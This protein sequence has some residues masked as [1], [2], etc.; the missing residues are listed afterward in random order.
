V[1]PVIRVSPSLRWVFALI[2]VYV[3]GAPSADT[4]N[5]E[6]D[7]PPLLRVS[8]VRS[9]YG[10]VATGSPEATEAA[11]EILE[12]GGNAIDAA[13]TAAL[14]LGV[15]DA[16]ASGIGGLTYMVIH[17]SNGRTVAIDGTSYAP[18]AIDMESFAQ[19]KKTGR[20]FGYELISTPTTLATLEF[21]RARY[22][23]M[24]MA[25]LL[26]PAIEVAENGYALSKLQVVWTGKYYENI[27]KSSNYMRYLAMEDGKT[28][29]TPGDH[30][31]AP[32]LANTYRRIARE[33]VRSF[34]FGG[35]ADE[36][37]ADMIRN[38]SYLRKSDL[39]RV[40]IREVQPLHTSY[41]GFDVFT[42]PPP[43]G[44]A[45]LVSILNLLETYPSE[46]VADYSP[47]RHHVFIEACRIAAA[48]APLADLRQ[49]TFGA[50]PLSKKH[51]RDRAPLIVPGKAI[52]GDLLAN[53]IPP[54]C[55]TEGY[56]TTQ[57]SIADSMGNVVSLTQTLSRSF[58]AKAATPGLGFSYNNFLEFFSADKPHCPGYLKPNS[59]CRT[60]MAPTIVL[61]D[62][63][64]LVALGAPGSSKI[65][66]LI[67]DV[68]SQMVDRGL[69]V[70]DAVI[71][72]RV[73][74]G[75]AEN[76]PTAYIELVGPVTEEDVQALEEMGFQGIITLSYPPPDPINLADFGGVNAVG[77]DP[78]TGALTGVGDPRRYGSAMGARVV[79]TA[80][81]SAR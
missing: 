2:A 41:R 40:R 33:G 6:A 15:S 68:I 54:E 25:T 38:G 34:Y 39:A 44:G 24:E 51:A 65:P 37:E 1:I 42:V 67:A 74:W 46:F 55:E 64:L 11:V 80:M 77:H 81:S 4:T 3:V 47:E 70:R 35:I 48:D 27:M 53:P 75:A 5:R 36:I 22:G 63:R 79:A 32:D 26:Q 78:K 73:L 10:M 62:G 8:E 49:K 19:F 14:T 31:C 13:V 45:E 61:K 59:P 57:V 18:M 7:L 43:G 66:K 17:L 58:G 50:D 60:G 69:G 71:A 76:E 72:P 23:T 52:P 21:A 29:G 16:D 12:H 20:N 9:D 30:L 56:S 28:L